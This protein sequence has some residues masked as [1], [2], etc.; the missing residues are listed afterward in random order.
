MNNMDNI[1]MNDGMI[2]NNDETFVITINNDNDST[3]TNNNN[4]DD[5]TISDLKNNHNDYID[6]ND[7]DNNNSS[8]SSSSSTSNITNNNNTTTTTTTD[9][10]NTKINKRSYNEMQATDIKDE[11]TIN[12]GH[13]EKMII[14]SI[15]N[16]LD[17]I[18]DVN[19][20]SKI[21]QM[22]HSKLN[23][24]EKK[25]DNTT[26]SS[27][28]RARYN[29]NDNEKIDDGDVCVTILNDINP[30]ILNLVKLL[31]TDFEYDDDDDD[32]DDDNNK[33]G[34]VV[35]HFL[36]II[37]DAVY[38]IIKNDEIKMMTLKSN[39]SYR[40]SDIKLFLKYMVPEFTLSI[41]N[42]L[43]SSS[44]SSCTGLHKYKPN[45]GSLTMN[46]V[47]EY[48]KT[49]NKSH[50]PH[51][52]QQHQEEID[53]KTINFEDEHDDNNDNDNNKEEDDS[54]NTSPIGELINLLLSICQTIGRVMR[55]STHNK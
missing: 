34:G 25:N 8:S 16:D 23:N 1:S 13:D 12:D 9:N 21:L 24:V 55:K 43:S 36:E 6:M 3:I 27:K 29:T 14:S 30:D 44:S 18:K 11:I 7:N 47:I 19:N 40:N 42:L 48:Q 22:I 20:Y 33:N 54:I 4:D 49:N 31:K 10:Q 38:K 15:I 52:N 37:R 46:H 41:M 50:H 45:Y 2:N 32:D 26:T 53:K 5:D 39:E 28:K 51:H 17:K 35:C